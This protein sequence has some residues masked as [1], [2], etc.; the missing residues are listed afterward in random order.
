MKAFL[1]NHTSGKKVLLW[2]LVTNVVYAFMLVYSVPKV[3]AYARNLPLPDLR[4]G[5]YD[6]AY[7]NNLFA[8]LGEAGRHAYLT[9]QLPI[10]FIYPFL[11]GVSNCLILA[12]F[13]KKIGKAETNLIYLCLLPLL[14]GF[15]DYL[16][17][18]CLVSMLQNFPEIPAGLVKMGS[19]FTLFKSGFSTL[20]FLVLILTL[21]VFLYQK[22][23]SKTN[24]RPVAN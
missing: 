12:Y 17:N 9:I 3:S 2:F 8:A 4:P 20:Y 5:G 1:I 22:F 16:E 11:F 6:L 14:G 15:F 7:I 18:I 21:L 24:T 13:L 19:I 23:F 10:D